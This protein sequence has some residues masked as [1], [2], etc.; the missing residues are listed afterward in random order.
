MPVPMIV[1]SALKLFTKGAFTTI[2]G[3]LFQ[4]LT[5]RLLKVFTRTLSLDLFV[6]FEGATF[7]SSLLSPCK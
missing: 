3:R 2:S 7:G 6:Q 1:E 5:T 4:V